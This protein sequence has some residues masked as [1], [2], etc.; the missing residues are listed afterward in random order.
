MR[1]TQVCPYSLDVPG[2]VGT[3]V[4]GLASWLSGQGHEVCV[5]APGR[6]RP[7]VAEAVQVQL[8]GAAVGLGFNGSTARLALGAH[9]WR[10]A[11]PGLAADVIHVHEPLT[12]GLAYALARRSEH[13]VVTHHAHFPVGGWLGPVL[14]MRARAL[15]SHRRAIAV[16][17]AAAVT[18]HGAT[19]RQSRV[20]ANAI[21]WPSPP[22]A[23]G[24]PWR[25]G[26]RPRITFVGR[27]NEPRKGFGAFDALARSVLDAEFVAVGP[28][29]CSSS[30][31]R[32]LGQLDSAGLREA[33][34]HTDIVVAPNR[35]GESFGMVLIE[36]L[37]AGARIVATDLPPF[38]R[39][40]GENPHAKL[41]KPE[42][43]Q[44]LV[45]AVRDALAQPADPMG[46]HR[47][48]SAWTWDAI[49]PLVLEELQAV[50]TIA[51]NGQRRGAEEHPQQ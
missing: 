41:V 45:A 42:S 7:D 8:V 31:V 37:A 4:L 17:P 22:S 18:A 28:G 46:A 12:P 39:V 30:A 49:G 40:L 26:V 1:I 23:P 33:L 51:R 50:A 5:V 21:S 11:R 20:I 10:R 38:R 13:L 25:G 2:G 36:A 16:S 24:G 15:P 44:A 29:R 35:F 6:S 14:R 43:P 19:G 3:H 9:Q 47:S 32:H 48:V 27:L 34:W